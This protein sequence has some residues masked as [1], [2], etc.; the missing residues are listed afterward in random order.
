M[1]ASDIKN[2]VIIGLS[3]A[4]V[5]ALIS[6]MHFMAALDRKQHE[7]DTYVAEVKIMKETDR[8]T[9]ERIRRE[10]AEALTEKQNL[11]HTA[12]IKHKEELNELQNQLTTARNTANRVRDNIVYINSNWDSYDDAARQNYARTAGNIITECVSESGE[13]EQ[14]A[15]GYNSEV[16]YLR[17]FITNMLSVPAFKMINLKNDASVTY[18]GPIEV[19]IK[20]SSIR[21]PISD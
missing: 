9:I 14:L 10:S 20:D 17:E 5:C 3:V 1:F 19:E 21:R 7:F 11:I 13:M 16:V 18:T 4:F 15:R 6:T 12:E 2:W 8:A